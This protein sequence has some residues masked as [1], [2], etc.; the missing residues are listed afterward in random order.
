MSSGLWYRIAL[1]SEQIAGGHVEIVRRL[2]AS[3]VTDARVPAG[4]CMFATSHD[5]RSMRLREDTGDE[6][7]V[8]A[9]AL[10]FSPQAIS[11]VPHLIA[12]YGA[13]PSEP[14][15]RSRAALLVGVPEDW[16]LLPR[17]SH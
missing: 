13:K 14:P 5:T 11:A 4:A 17:S 10:F 8:N 2:F 16:D 7:P 12:Q 1:T 9:D 6:S 15:D 3:A